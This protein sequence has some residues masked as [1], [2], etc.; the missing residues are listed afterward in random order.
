MRKA[1]RNLWNC[2]L[3]G[4]SKSILNPKRMREMCCLKVI[5]TLDSPVWPHQKPAEPQK[6]SKPVRIQPSHSSNL[7]LRWQMWRSCWRRFTWFEFMMFPWGLGECIVFYA[8]NKALSEQFPL[9][10]NK[11]Q[12]QGFLQGSAESPLFVTTYSREIWTCLSNITT[13]LISW[14]LCIRETW[15]YVRSLV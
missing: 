3:N 13:S 1:N 14:Q 10:E 11:W 2:P 8:F 6:P 4:E 15:S 12:D 7:K 9:S 5:A